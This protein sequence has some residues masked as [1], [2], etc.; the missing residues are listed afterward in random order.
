MQRRAGKERKKTPRSINC[1]EAR[2]VGP[3]RPSDKKY[4]FCVTECERFVRAKGS[5]SPAVLLRVGDDDKLERYD[6]VEKIRRMGRERQTLGWTC[7]S[8]NG[9]PGESRLNVT[10]EWRG[11]GERETCSADGSEDYRP[12][13]ARSRRCEPVREARWDGK[14]ERAAAVRA[15][16]A[17]TCPAHALRYQTRDPPATDGRVLARF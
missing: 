3:S 5:P 14:P 8:S 1:D 9:G 7:R 17:R 12:L 13:H 16:F 10:A 2:R 11:G 15:V 6:F 4:D